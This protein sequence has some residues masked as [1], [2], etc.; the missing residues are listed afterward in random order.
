MVHAEEEGVAGFPG[1][2]EGADAEDAGHIRC[3][4]VV[5]Y[6]NLGG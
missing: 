3:V 5:F 6:T 1:K 2:A 4:L